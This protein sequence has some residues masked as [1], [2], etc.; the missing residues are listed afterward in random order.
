[1]AELDIKERPRGFRSPMASGSRARRPSSPHRRSWRTR[2][3]SSVAIKDRTTGSTVIGI[4]KRMA[5]APMKPAI[6]SRSRGEPA[7]RWPAR[8]TLTVPSG[9]TRR[10]IH[11]GPNSAARV[12]TRPG[13]T[14]M[15]RCRCIGRSAAMSARRTG[16]SASPVRWRAMEPAAPVVT[17]RSGTSLWMVS[18][19]GNG[20][21][22]T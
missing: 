15:R 8:I 5:T 9:T 21:S 3:R 14:G 16:R 17:A 10:A 4:R 20:R 2:W 18:R 7:A 19:S 22:S 11:R 13:K 12:A 1:M 6:S